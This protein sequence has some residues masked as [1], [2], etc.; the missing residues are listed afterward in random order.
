MS[1]HLTIALFLCFFTLSCSNDIDNNTTSTK[2][3]LSISSQTSLSNSNQQTLSLNKDTIEKG[4]KR[5]KLE[6]IGSFIYPDSRLEVQDASI[7]TFLDTLKGQ[8]TVPAPP[9]R[10]TLQQ[11]G[12]NSFSNLD[13]YVRVMVETYSGSKGDFLKSNL[14]SV[15]DLTIEEQSQIKEYYKSDIA[16]NFKRAGVTIS[17]W[18]PVELLQING[19]FCIL[20]RYTRQ[21]VSDK[22]DVLVNLYCFPDNDREFDFTLACRVGDKDKW[23]IDFEKI[24][25]SFTV[26]KTVR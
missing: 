12:F 22:G 20:L 17:K 16:N 6:G 26:V 11:Q 3:Q 15:K 8:L 1:P 21:T 10:F 25:K 9:A 7:K 14:L 19:A 2:D 13:E 5:V 23:S 24:I 18:Y 4:W